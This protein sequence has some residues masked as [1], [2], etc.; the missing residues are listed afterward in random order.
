MVA[1]SRVERGVGGIR[2]EVLIKVLNLF[3]GGR[4]DGDVLG[5]VEGVDAVVREVGGVV[6]A[7]TQ[8]HVVGVGDELVHPEWDWI[9]RAWSMSFETLMTSFDSVRL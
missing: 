3:R 5:A 6:D 1:T 7:A 9:Y 4:E 2:Y 8:V